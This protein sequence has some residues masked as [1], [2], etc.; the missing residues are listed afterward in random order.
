MEH[1]SSPG[2]G[3]VSSYERLNWAPNRWHSR[4]REH[5]SADLSTELDVHTYDDLDYHG[6][7][8]NGWGDGWPNVLL[9]LV[10][11]VV[12]LLA[13]LIGTIIRL[14]WHPQRATDR[15]HVRWEGK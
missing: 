10:S 11:T 9:L 8:D 1:Q 6:S 3:R 2:A 5:K 13:G 7:E 4:S 15:P 12:V 14:I